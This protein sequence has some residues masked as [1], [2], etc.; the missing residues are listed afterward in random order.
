MGLHVLVVT[1]EAGP[2]AMAYVERTKL[3]WP[4]LI[5][6]TRSLYA[7]Y[8]MERGRW[9]DIL[10]WSAWTAYAKLLWHGRRL[11][12]SSGDLRQLGGDV[13]I[14]PAAIVRAHHVGSGPADRPSVRSLLEVVGSGRSVEADKLAGQ[15]DKRG[16]RDAI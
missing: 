15:E 4:L 5:D 16:N 14:D 13:L 9:R 12:G 1:F 11:Q 8:G 6:E 7:A 3:P 10:G 2:L